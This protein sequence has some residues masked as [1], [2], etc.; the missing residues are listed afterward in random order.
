MLVSP[1]ETPVA[2]VTFRDD[3]PSNVWKLS[4]AMIGDRP[5]RADL[6]R[7]PENPNDCHAIK[8][9]IQEEHVG[10]IPAL[11]AGSLSKEI[12]NG[13]QWVAV[14]DRIVVSPENAEQPG[15]RLRVM[16]TC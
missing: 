1:I 14:V 6:V 10:Y 3:Y 13:D 9:V 7:E 11:I 12:D 8:V 4:G 16:K 5:V 15:I 2:G